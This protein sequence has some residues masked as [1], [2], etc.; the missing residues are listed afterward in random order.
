MIY[1]DIIK[2]KFKESID[3]KTK[4]LEND[5]IICEI[6]KSIREICLRLNKGNRIFICGNGGSASDALHITG[7]LVGRFQKE[8]KSIPCIA[9]NSNITNL[10]A[11]ANDYGYEQVFSRQVEGLMKKEDIL[12]G[13]STSGNSENILNA[14]CCAKELGA[15]T[16]VFTGKD[17]GR[18]KDIADICI[19]IPHENSARIQEIHIIIGHILCEVIEETFCYEK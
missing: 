13:I 8:R 4:I 7:E 9:L 5:E 3:L 14:V 2:R 15:L 6:E 11:I 17:G 12:L 19:V 1:K 18:L 10:T 16:V